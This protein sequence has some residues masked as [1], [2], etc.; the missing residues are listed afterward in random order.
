MA[1]SIFNALFDFDLQK[2]IL[3]FFFEY[4]LELSKLIR[5]KSQICYFVE[6]LILIT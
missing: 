1:T 5:S 6:L 2:M 4:F 3:Y